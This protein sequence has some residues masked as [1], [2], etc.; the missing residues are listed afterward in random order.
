M[1]TL[2]VP[3]LVVLFRSVFPPNIATQ[4]H[5][6]S[7]LARLYHSPTTQPSPPP[8]ADV[9]SPLAGHQAVTPEAGCA[10]VRAWP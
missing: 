9:P 4:P 3:L 8:A 2:L 1:R 5:P 7:F 10:A 6:L